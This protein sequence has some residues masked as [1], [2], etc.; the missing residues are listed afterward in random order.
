ML[1]DILRQC[2]KEYSG[3]YGNGNTDFHA[4]IIRYETTKHDLKT[5]LQKIGSGNGNGFAIART[6]NIDAFCKYI[7]NPENRF[8]DR[9]KNGDISLVYELTQLGSRGHCFSAATK[10]CTLW[11]ESLENI[12]DHSPVH[13]APFV[14]ADSFV[15]DAL[16]N[17]NTSHR[18]TNKDIK[19]VYT[20]RDYEKWHQIILDFKKE[21]N[22]EEFTEREIDKSL[23]ILWNHF[24]NR[25][26]LD[27]IACPLYGTS[28]IHSGDDTIKLI[29]KTNGKQWDFHKSDADPF[30]WPETRLHGHYGHKKLNPFTGEIYDV[31]KKQMIGF[32]P[33]KELRAIQAHLKSSKDFAH[34][35]DA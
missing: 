32:I 34:Y 33:K 12:S 31:Q 10:I 23:W 27:C 15:R 9:I 3:L 6:M 24:I 4:A 16:N 2:L 25:S 5:L 1:T 7:E 22:L 8:S 35:F 20:N 14:I 21:F 17:I 28:N 18:F 29:T 13:P 26:L 30:P 19:K 11:H